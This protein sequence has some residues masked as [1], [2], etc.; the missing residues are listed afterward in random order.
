ML[1]QTVDVSLQMGNIRFHIYIQP[2]A[3][4]PRNG[5]RLFSILEGTAEFQADDRTFFLKDQD[6]IL[7]SPYIK[8]KEN[9]PEDTRLFI[10]DISYEYIETDD[11]ENL[12]EMFSNIFTDTV[13]LHLKKVAE[14]AKIAEATNADL[15]G[16][17][18]GVIYRLRTHLT[19]LLFFLSDTVLLLKQDNFSVE[20]TSN[21]EQ[22]A[23]MRAMFIDSYL[24]ENFRENITMQTLAQ[25]LSLSEKQ[26]GRIIKK[27]YGRTF[28]Q[29]LTHLRINQAIYWLT[30][31]DIPAEEIAYT[32]GYAT[33][34]G[35]YK[36]FKQITGMSPSEYREKN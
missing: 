28:Y 32:V 25:K 6:L 8:Y 3:S 34:T 31:S 19:G 21:K 1:K 9:I 24:N 11:T 17:Y 29:Q 13:C 16:K 35:F 22:Y 5:H 18:A 36:A 26:I 12:Y 7:L 20:K 30:T 14:A 2:E 33:Y 4:A 27:M 15:S 23:N 10:L